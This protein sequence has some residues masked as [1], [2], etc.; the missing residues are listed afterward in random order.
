ML[1]RNDLGYFEEYVKYISLTVG[2]S[3]NVLIYKLHLK[4]LKNIDGLAMP[5]RD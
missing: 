4:K 5:V 1:F 2:E 3:F